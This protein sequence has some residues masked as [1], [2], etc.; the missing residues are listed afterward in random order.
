MS[1]CHLL[2]GHCLHIIK[3]GLLAQTTNNREDN[4]LVY[5]SLRVKDWSEGSRISDDITIMPHYYVSI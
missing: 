1:T 3:Y 2:L 4:D 5:T